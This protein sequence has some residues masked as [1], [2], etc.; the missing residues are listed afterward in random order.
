VRHRAV[1]HLHA[2]ETEAVEAAAV[3]SA[4]GENGGEA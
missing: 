3:A 4:N 1:P 2:A